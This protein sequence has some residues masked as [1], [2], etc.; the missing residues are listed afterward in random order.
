[1]EL[2]RSIGRIRAAFVAAGLSPD[3]YCSNGGRR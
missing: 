3:E 2:E 1:L